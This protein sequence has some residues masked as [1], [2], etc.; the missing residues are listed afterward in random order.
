MVNENQ[1]NL[2]RAAPSLKVLM[3]C[4]IVALSV[5]YG[6]ALLQIHDR[7]DFKMEKA[8]THFRGVPG[9]PEG[10]SLPQT[11]ATMISIAHVHSFA[12]PALLGLMGLM[13]AFTGLSERKK[14]FWILLSFFGSLAT[15]MSPWLIRDVSPRFVYMLSASGF[16]MFLS[17]AVMAG[18]VL[19]ELW[20][21]RARTETRL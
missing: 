16:S 2:S 17:F 18:V 9:D 20:F 15:N 7:S 8:A 6:V 10:L 19:F 5:G 14:I 3:T 12:Q 13:F 1:I 11:D 21:K 4:F